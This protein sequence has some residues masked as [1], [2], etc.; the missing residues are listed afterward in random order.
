LSWFACDATRPSKPRHRSAPLRYGKKM[1]QNKKSQCDYCA[2]L[3]LEDQSNIRSERDVEEKYSVLRS[4]T[5]APKKTRKISIGGDDAKTETCFI[6]S[7]NWT[8]SK[9]NQTHC[10]DFIDNNIPRP[11]ALK[12][13][14]N[15]IAIRSLA[16]GQD[17]S[18]Q[19]KQWC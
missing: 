11:D 12:S 3:Y 17:S 10:D 14:E 9:N 16:R 2:F 4:L 1:N 8:P 6:N 13:R 18:K 15:E 7:P 19:C 5:D